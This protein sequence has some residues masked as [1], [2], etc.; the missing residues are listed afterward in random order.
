M[1]IKL[2]EDYWIRIKSD[3]REENEDRKYDGENAFR[4]LH[5]QI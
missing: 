1:Q 3:Y 4:G 2:Q 5:A